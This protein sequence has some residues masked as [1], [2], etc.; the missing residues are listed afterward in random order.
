MNYYYLIKDD[1]L[2][3]SNKKIINILCLKKLS[4]KIFDVEPKLPSV[5][6]GHSE[7]KKQF[8]YP[9]TAAQPC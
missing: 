8:C 6:D 5:I 9:K 4:V 3:K 1:V 7:L 2:V